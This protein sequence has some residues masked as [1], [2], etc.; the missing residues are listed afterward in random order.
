[1]EHAV[2]I[3]IYTG[4]LKKRPKVNYQITAFMNGTEFVKS[5]QKMK[6]LPLQDVSNSIRLTAGATSTHKKPWYDSTFS[7]TWF[8]RKLREKGWCQDEMARG[9]FQLDK[10]SEMNLNK[11]SQSIKC[12]MKKETCK[13]VYVYY[14]CHCL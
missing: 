13:H 6:Y 10:E 12:G 11:Y 2:Y 7:V 3:Y 8:L 1:M 5:E 9:L 4:W 14:T